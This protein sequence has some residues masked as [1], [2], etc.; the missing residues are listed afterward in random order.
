MAGRK[1]TGALEGLGV[2]GR[3]QATEVPTP[4]VASPLRNQGS[5]P[6]L[7][8]AIFDLD[9]T[10]KQAPDPYVYLHERLGT[11]AAS[12]AFFQQG[13]S[14]KV[15]YE[16]WLRLDAALWKGVSRKRIEALF[17]ENPYLLGARETV[18]E[19]QRSGVRVALLSTG[20][21]VHAE[22]V[23]AELGIDRIVANE[24]LFENGLVS[25]EVRVHVPEGRKVDVVRRLMAEF[26][27]RRDECLAVGDGTSDADVF[28]LVRL[29]VAV[30]PSSD[31]VRQ[32]AGLVLEKPDLRPLMALVREVFA[33]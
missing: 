18:A 31:R 13:V 17:R 3:T 9:G 10:L 16:E 30:N 8:L 21:L 27:V 14:G 15:G 12:Q 23:G 25:G 19:L 20:L 29:G 6:S 24:I 32:A 11:L 2:S 5:K 28:P 33:A 4:P 7:R 26:V 1:G 22:Q